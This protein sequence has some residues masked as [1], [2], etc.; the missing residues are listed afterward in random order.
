M[1]LNVDPN[2]VIPDERKSIAD[3]AIEPWA[4]VFGSENIIVNIEGSNTIKYAH[5]KRADL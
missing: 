4:K 3:G 5:Y 2:L 1:K